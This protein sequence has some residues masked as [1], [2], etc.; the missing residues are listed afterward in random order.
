[1]LSKRIIPCLDV[2]NGKLTKGIKF[3]G[4]VDIGDP[5]QMA[6]NYYEEGADEIVFYDITASSEGRDIMIDTVRRVAEKIFIP[7]CVGG[8]IRSVEDM[9]QVLLAGAEKV[10]VNSAA[11]R[12]PKII[13]G[14]AE[15][16]G[17][18]CIV[19][20]MDVKKVQP[21]EHIPSGYEIVIDGGRSYT[22]IDAL[23]WARRG[24][25]LGAG[26]ICLNSIDADGTKDGYELELNGLISSNVRIPVIASG[27]AG[28]PEH[29][30]EVLSG[31]RA[32]AA[33]IAS[34][35]HYGTYSIKEIKE[36]LHNK[37][38]KVRMNW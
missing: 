18:Q 14:G 4:N 29:L 30:F 7:F 24:E 15:S 10:S 23:A 27:G 26:E 28:S 25:T 36:Y 9:R 16:F 22:G 32:D 33:L 20:G 11:V 35:T 5:V 13:S 8:G 1:M 3:K 6:F 19:L 34:M 2:R 31:G 38:I 21:T 17:S 37:G 12:D